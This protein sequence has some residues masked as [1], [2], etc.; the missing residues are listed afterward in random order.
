MERREVSSFVLRGQRAR[1]DGASGLTATAPGGHVE[2]QGGWDSPSQALEQLSLH[3]RVDQRCVEI[4]VDPK[5]CF[6][7]LKRA[8]VW[9]SRNEVL[10]AR[11]IHL[12][13]KTCRH[14]RSKKCLTPRS[15]PSPFHYLN[16]NL[17]LLNYSS[18]ESTGLS[19]II[20]SR[21]GNQEPFLGVK[22]NLKHQE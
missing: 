9:S 17:L 18:F 14:V 8:S 1:G 6:C 22:G 16:R 12:K 20:T 13:R 21:A 15:L 5:H 4:R 7:S 2:P 10:V 11:N 3:R 19:E